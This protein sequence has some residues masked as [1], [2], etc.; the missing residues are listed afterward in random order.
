MATWASNSA[1]TSD[2]WLRRFALVHA[3]AHR[4]LPASHVCGALDGVDDVVQGVKGAVC[5]VAD[6]GQDVEGAISDV[7]VDCC[8]AVDRKRH[9]H[10]TKQVHEALQDT[11]SG[12]LPARQ[13]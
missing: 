7:P 10:Q 3:Q 8:K 12:A 5:I 13:M 11:Q 1:A 4:Q 2:G 6:G 9:R